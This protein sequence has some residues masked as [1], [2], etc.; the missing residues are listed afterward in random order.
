MLVP[1]RSNTDRF[2][3]NTVAAALNNTVAAAFAAVV[4]AAAVAPN[5][6]GGTLR[7]ARRGRLA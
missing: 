6:A 2:P 4:V 1:V 5:T 3:E 7:Q